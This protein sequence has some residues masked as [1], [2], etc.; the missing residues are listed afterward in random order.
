MSYCLWDFENSR[1]M[2]LQGLHPLSL[3][4]SR[5]LLSGFMGFFGLPAWC[6]NFSCLCRFFELCSSC[7]CFYG[8]TLLLLH[9]NPQLIPYL[10]CSFMLG[11][12]NFPLLSTSQGRC[13][14]VLG[15]GVFFFSFILSWCSRSATLYRFCLT[16][17][18][19]CS[20]T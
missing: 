9:R 11:V 7:C 13:F 10:Y 4:I 17:F 8:L 3:F 5:T 1:L 19:R 14:R 16:F 20:L 18:C 15:F 12:E 2:S 6:R